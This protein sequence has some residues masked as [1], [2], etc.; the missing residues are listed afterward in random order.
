MYCP[1]CKEKLPLD[2]LEIWDESDKEVGVIFHCAE[3]GDE[4]PITIAQEDLLSP[5]R[6][7]TNHDKGSP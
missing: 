2:L 7:L 1:N 6:Q 4:F 5:Q 3:C